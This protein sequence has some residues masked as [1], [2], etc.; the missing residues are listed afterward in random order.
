MISLQSNKRKS[1][2]EIKTICAVHEDEDGYLL[3]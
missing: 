3:G 2:V 1:D